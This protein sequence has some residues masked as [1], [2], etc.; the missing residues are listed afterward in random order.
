M[1]KYTIKQIL[2]SDN[3]NIRCC[4]SSKDSSSNFWK[5]NFSFLVVFHGEYHISVKN[6]F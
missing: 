2:E 1:E 5:T 6:N 3:T 4:Q